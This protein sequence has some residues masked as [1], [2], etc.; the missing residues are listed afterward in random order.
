MARKFKAPRGPKTLFDKVKDID[1]SFLEEVYV[2][3][4]EQLKAKLVGI[5]SE[6]TRLEKAKEDD[7]D[8]QQKQE[9]ARV[10]G[11]TYSIP[12]KAIKLKRQMIFKVLEER[13]KA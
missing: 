4:E 13:G 12:F 6:Q 5:L 11:E 7:K 2:L 8:L 10:A 9:Q 1:P 3:S